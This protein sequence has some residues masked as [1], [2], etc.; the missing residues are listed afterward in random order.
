[1]VNRSTLK[2]DCKKIFNEQNFQ[3]VR[4]NPTV[5]PLVAKLLK[6]PC[7]NIVA[8]KNDCSQEGSGEHFRMVTINFQSLIDCLNYLALPSRPDIWFAANALLSLV[9]NSVEAHWKAAKRVLRYL[10]GTINKNLS[11]LKS[12]IMNLLIFSYADWAGNKGKRRSTS[13]F[14]SS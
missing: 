12:Q 14:F 11:F 2:K 9:D 7:S 13:Y 1:M 5:T 8:S 3:N 4:L 10:E 6:L